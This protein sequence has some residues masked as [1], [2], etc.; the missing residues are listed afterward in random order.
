MTLASTVTL[1][2]NGWG[3]PFSPYKVPL[4]RLHITGRSEGT[5][6]VGILH[7]EAARKP[8][9]REVAYPNA[10]L[11][12]AVVTDSCGSGSHTDLL[13][14]RCTIKNLIAVI[15]PL[16]RRPAAIGEEPCKEAS[17]VLGL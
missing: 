6:F 3:N 9:S 13:G 8:P 16:T 17:A 14:A 5:F 12:S 7:V 4:D 1:G 2:M 15:S 10:A 11:C